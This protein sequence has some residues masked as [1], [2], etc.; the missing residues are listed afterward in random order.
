[1]SL[2]QNALSSS[3]ALIVSLFR[4][5]SY[6][7]SQLSYNKVHGS[8]FVITDAIIAFS[9]CSL[10]PNSACTR[11]SNVPESFCC[12]SLSFGSRQRV[13]CFLRPSVWTPTNSRTS[14]H[15][16]TMPQYHVHNTSV[17]I[18]KKQPIVRHH[19]HTILCHQ[20]TIFTICIIVNKMVT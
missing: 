19:G 12:F 5:A 17:A 13:L 8:Q 14:W 20:P 1:M 15:V 18:A 16:C 6:G 4:K 3:A 2:N 7:D 9:R 10:R 11:L